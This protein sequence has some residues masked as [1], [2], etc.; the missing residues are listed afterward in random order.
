MEDRVVD[1]PLPFKQRWRERLHKVKRLSVSK[2][3]LESG[4]TEPASS[5]CPSVAI[6]IDVSPAAFACQPLGQRVSRRE[7]HG[8]NTSRLELAT[9]EKLVILPQ[10]VVH[11]DEAS[12]HIV[13]P[14]QTTSPWKRFW[15]IVANIPPPTWAVGVGL[16]FSLVPPLKALLYSTPSWTGTRMPNAPDGNPPLNF[17]LETAEFLGALTV[18]LALIVL[19]ASFARLK[20]V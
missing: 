1:D 9:G 6:D 14:Q 7:S 16:I 12:I 3:V 19:G 13:L 15:R 5:N 4:P 8:S 20:V 10:Q 18:P 17:V 2:N 11:Q